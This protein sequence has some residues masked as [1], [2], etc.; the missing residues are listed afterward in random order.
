[1][2][3]SKLYK[4]NQKQ[5]KEE[6]K[7]P[8]LLKEQGGGPDKGASQPAFECGDLIQYND[9]SVAMVDTNDPVLFNDAYGEFGVEGASSWLDIN[10]E[11]VTTN[12]AGNYCVEGV[13]EIPPFYIC[14]SNANP[15]NNNSA[16]YSI[17][18]YQLDS[19]YTFPG[20][21]L[22]NNNWAV[23]AAGCFCPTPNVND[24]ILIDCGLGEDG[25]NF[26]NFNT[27][28]SI[29]DANGVAG[30]ELQDGIFTL[31]IAISCGGTVGPDD[32]LGC[33]DN[34]NLDSTNP[35]APYFSPW[36]GTT[37]CN[38]DE[39]A[40]TDD[41]TQCT[42]DC[43]GCNDGTSLNSNSEIPE[44][45]ACNGL[46]N[47][48]TGEPCCITGGCTNI[49][50]TNPCLI[51]PENMLSG[52]NCDSQPG[53]CEFNYCS[54]PSSGLYICNAEVWPG[55]MIAS[56]CVE[57]TDVQLYQNE[58]I[59][60]YPDT[61]LGNFTGDCPDEEEIT[62]GCV[63]PQAINYDPEI[64]DPSAGCI[65]DANNYEYS[66]ITPVCLDD[67]AFGNQ[68]TEPMNVYGYPCTGEWMDTCVSDPNLCVHEG[69]NNP[70]GV[71]WEHLCENADDCDG[72][73]TPIPGLFATDPDGGETY[74]LYYY[75]PDNTGCQTGTDVLNEYN[76]DCCP[77][78]GC[79]DPDANN[80]GA[81]G[82]GG[83]NILYATYDP[84]GF[85]TSPFDPEGVD[86]IP[87]S[88]EYDQYGCTDPEAINY[89]GPTEDGGPTDDD[90]TCY[91]CKD[92]LAYQCDPGM[93]PDEIIEQFQETANIG[94]WE[95]PKL[96]SCLTIGTENN[97]NGLGVPMGNQ[98]STTGQFNTF[99]DGAS[100]Y[101]IAG[102]SD[103]QACNYSEWV[104]LS[105][106]SCEYP[107][108]YYDCEGNCIN[109]T[110]GDGVCDELEQVGCMD[111]TALN[112]NANATEEDNSLC[113]YDI[114]G[115][116]DPN[117]TN[118]NEE[119]TINNDTCIYAGCQ[120]WP[121]T[122]TTSECV[123]PDQCP[124][125]GLVVVTQGGYCTPYNADASI[126]QGG[127]EWTSIMY[128]EP[129]QEIGVGNLWGL[130]NSPNDTTY[131][132]PGGT[133]NTDVL[134]LMTVCF[135]TYGTVAYYWYWEQLTLCIGNTCMS[136][137]MNAI[138]SNCASIC[139]A[140]NTP[141]GGADW[142]EVYN[143]PNLSTCKNL[144]KDYSYGGPMQFMATGC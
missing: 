47:Q 87:L 131:G 67:T 8:T 31:D 50:A 137:I 94:T 60:W 98:P 101:Y 38:Y 13:V 119:A 56:L 46:F 45:N 20:Y 7:K 53:A 10:N 106:D 92:V 97:T 39:T 124:P 42:Y 109:D 122:T 81:W 90:G 79:T 128:E 135:P 129:Y 23:G 33:M 48:I 99:A 138:E 66:C 43:I 76:S 91:Y 2:K 12:A 58:N 30:D 95:N 120:C 130:L 18:A 83:T 40:T 77:R 114:E 63:Y 121:E 143:C 14:C 127:N 142:M 65:D 49:W 61:S 100:V 15:D 3:K 74:Q 86:Q 73:G 4:L 80:T 108:S 140:T 1:M 82:A 44:E 36:V 5:V 16:A 113:N 89:G 28:V 144:C 134:G 70:L 24:G 84:A 71:E 118:Y 22:E 41:G 116:T 55:S 112:Y 9:L 93:P 52:F 111:D 21:D 59:L 51:D 72:P 62:Y 117:A 105:V 27:W 37:A 104:N 69:C 17:G 75:H 96:F 64:C 126:I 139:N 19:V 123:T 26:Q 136:A 6:L 103:P 11:L 34:G 102:C 35:N 54:D 88:C 107:P 132:P 141:G 25:N 115:C 133:T 125:N 110:D 78:P 85:G 29:N 32:I 68:G 57:A